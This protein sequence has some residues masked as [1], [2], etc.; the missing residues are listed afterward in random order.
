ML[1]DLL[2][3]KELTEPLVIGY[4]GGGN[5]GDELL[6]E[7]L[8]LLF[9]QN[10]ITKVSVYYQQ[11]HRY[12]TYHH[13]FDFTIVD[14]GK[15]WS[16][17]KQILRSKQIVIGGGGLWGLDFNW[18]IFLLSVLLY[19]YSVVLR[20]PV[21]LVG[22]GYYSSTTRI[23]RISAWIAAKA[24]KLILARDQ[25]TYD[26]FA[27]WSPHVELDMDISFYLPKIDLSAYAGE[28]DELALRFKLDEPKTVI[29]LRRFQSKHQ[30]T[31]AQLIVDIVAETP[32]IKFVIIMLEPNEVDPESYAR[33]QHLQR[34]HDNVKSL[35]F[36]YNPLALYVLCKRHHRQLRLIAPQYHAI[37]TALQNDLPFLPIC[38]DNKVAQI[39]AMHNITPIAIKDVNGQMIKSF[40]DK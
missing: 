5:Y 12:L 4:Y 7:T 18:S 22:V 19:F 2:K 11:P 32:N 37:I 20:R 6:L 25:E 8:S 9:R 35:E 26:N 3:S 21:Y 15:K 36:N 13:N 30:N 27:K 29:A 40:L 10:D 31:Y 14:G 24:S 23:G 39:L 16:T 38:Y 33:L 1:L 28:A 17:V 34:A